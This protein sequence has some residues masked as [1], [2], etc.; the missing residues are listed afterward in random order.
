MIDTKLKSLL[1]ATALVAASATTA[2]AVT[3]VDSQETTAGGGVLTSLSPDQKELSTTFAWSDTPVSG[4]IQFTTTQA[5]DFYLTSY[6][7]ESGS[8]V[9]GYVLKEVGGTNYTTQTTFCDR[10]VVLDAIEGSCNLANG[11]YA[12]DDYSGYETTQPDSYAALGRYAAGTYY[13]GFYESGDPV[14]GSIG[15]R[16]SEVSASEVPVPA[17]GG[18][19]LAAL[20][21]TAALR[22]RRKS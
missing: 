3:T 4:Y 19:L 20:G 1:A 22:R 18:L 13:L 6:L 7:P 9:S 17:A 21:G 15:F 5:F 16:T 2:A 11:A 14:S 10:S 12:T 8:T